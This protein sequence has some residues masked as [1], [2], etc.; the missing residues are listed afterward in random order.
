MKDYED[1]DL[2]FDSLL[3]HTNL[4]IDSSY[5]CLIFSIISEMGPAPQF[6]FLLLLRILPA[7]NILATHRNKLKIK[8]NTENDHER[9]NY[10]IF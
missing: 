2:G 6:I 5:L 1:M 7:L 10:Q 4:N 8:I 3:P 9:V